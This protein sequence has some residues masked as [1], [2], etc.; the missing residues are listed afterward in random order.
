MHTTTTTF[1]V[2]V[3]SSGFAAKPL[4]FDDDRISI[5]HAA[6]LEEA[7]AALAA[8]TVD[9]V[10]C[11]ASDKTGCATL[12]R[13]VKNEF[14]QVPV[15]AFTGDCEASH[16]DELLQRGA[17]DV[18]QS[19]PEAASASLVLRR[20]QNVVDSDNGRA[21]RDETLERYETILNTAGDAIYQLDRMGTI[22][23]I[24]DAT[25]DLTGYKRWE[26]IGEHVSKL[27]SDEDIEAGEQLIRQQ[28]EDEN[29]RVDTLDMEIQRKDGETITCE[30]RIAV[31]RVDGQMTGSVGVVRDVSEKRERERELQR[32][33][34]LL[35]QI[36]DNVTDVVWVTNG[37]KN[38][39]EF[40][41][42][43]Y[44]QIWGRS[45]DE[46]YGNPDAFIEAVHPEDREA[47]EEALTRQQVDPDT[48]DETYR[49]VRPD[50]EIRYVH[51]RAFGVYDDEG[52]LTRIVGVARDITERR[53]AQQQLE[54]EHDM[55]AQGPAVVF[56]WA[57][58]AGW[59]VEYVSENVT[60]LLGYT[61]AEL[62]SGEISYAEL[63]HDDDIERVTTE[64][65]E[66]GDGTTERFSHEPYRLVTDEGETIWVKDSTK[67]VHDQGDVQQYLGYLVDITERKEREQELESLKEEYELM[68]DT[69]GDV[70]YT[71]DADFRFRSVNGAAAAV[72]GYTC[73]ELE[74]KHISTLVSED[75]LDRART[76]RD[77]VIGGEQETAT[78]E[79]E[80][81]E[82]DGTKRF[83]EFRYRKLPSDEEFIGTAGVIRDISERKRSE[84][85]VATQRDEL[86]QLNRLNSIIRGID[87]SLVGATTR[88]EVEQAVCDQLTHG[89]QYGFALALRLQGDDT[90]VPQA[91]TDAGEQFVEELFPA[92]GLDAEKS[93]GLRALKAGE[94]EVVQSLSEKT[95]RPYWQ[96]FMV[97]A[98]IEAVTA[99]P[100][101]YQDTEYGV[102]GVYSQ[103]ADAFSE[104]E[105]DVLGELGETVG[106]AIAAVERREREH[107]LTELYEATQS[108]LG[109]ETPQE[110]SEQV[111]SSAADVLG[112]PG[113]G[114]FLFDSEENVLEPAAAT[115]EL[116]EYYGHPRTFGP[117]RED[118][119]VWHS[120]ATGET[121]FYED[122]REA[123]RISNPETDARSSLLI[124][125][126]DHGAFVASSPRIDDFDE[127]MRNLVGLLAATTEAAL[128]RVAGRAGIRERDRE[129]QARTTQL[130]RIEEI[131]TCHRNIDQL[132]VEAESREEIERGVCECLVEHE[133]YTFAWVGT[134]PPDS[135]H[136][137]PRIWEG[138]ENG[139]LDSVSLEVGGA[140]PVTAAAET[141]ERQMVSNITDHLRDAE[142]ARAAT[143]QNFQSAIAVPLVYREA[144][145]GVLGVYAT[146]TDAFPEPVKSVLAE[147]GE[148]VAYG[149]SAIETTR[150]VLSEQMTELELQL[151]SPDTFLNSVSRVAGSPV[152]YRQVL[153]EEGGT[154]Q[155][156]FAL[157]DPPVEKVLALE[158]E[159]V[160]VEELTEMSGAEKQIFRTVLSG[161]TIAATLLRCGGLPKEIISEAEETRVVVEIPHELDVRVYLDR[162][163]ETYPEVSLVS[164]QSVEMESKPHP[165]LHSTLEA[166][167]T[168]R[169][170]EVL[171][172]AYTCGF[173]ESPRETTGAEL[174][175][176]LNISQPTLT[177]HLREAQRRLFATLY[178]ESE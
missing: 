87:Q 135:D 139:Y 128:D 65:A 84:E 49:I 33:N 155:V 143:N 7:T 114:I 141:G 53:E 107:V 63:I 71:L 68:V 148:L 85:K 74:G 144:T 77:R 154:T 177:H 99:I 162:L 78:I 43:A 100:I 4:A 88:E 93:P 24:N 69:I 54:A 115:P 168:E 166:N 42:A 174:A 75:A 38:Q 27:L 122:V 44:E 8:E 126:G 21:L 157:D 131:L 37:D 138:A 57:N 133:P 169:Q 56:R 150:G 145:Y 121:K 52:T 160:T 118:S 153:P 127:R 83:A 175:E 13:T 82:K 165:D 106:H 39:I 58:E 110:V 117:G 123:E 48:Y 170:R 41:S 105:I 90:F 31:I 178:E 89:G 116:M 149:I 55:F 159:F 51:D 173:F 2:L 142:W 95:E 151:Q 156:L 91:W 36:A 171:L 70:V 14:P 104:R 15:I 130:E 20:I 108:L 113:I 120:Y 30:T 132:L 124:P 16:I 164:R 1:E 22:V 62:K 23:A 80:I 111:V 40:I 64:V 146:K 119:E 129:L 11:A 152:T 112:P 136:I 61:P 161:E 98:G 137:E 109:A 12:V 158:E 10:L 167:L 101:R 147:V 34:E 50:G 102:I 6:S 32:R 125:L 76:V 25:A 60:D 163:K 17:T 35:D 46:L 79:F 3:L 66:F 59:P 26:L 5:T 28:L 18:I 94:V 97:E 96:D 72:T 29:D 140:E 92:D 134:V 47:V 86:A 176:L 45:R 172:T 9:C 81:D 103:Q 67:V 73:E 19:A